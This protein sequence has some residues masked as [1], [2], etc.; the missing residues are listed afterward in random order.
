V[1]ASSS[2]Y[3][4]GSVLDAGATTPASDKRRASVASSKNGTST[5]ASSASRSVG[6]GA[7][8]LG[9]AASSSTIAR[10]ITCSTCESTRH[11]SG[12]ATSHGAAA[13]HVSI[14]SGASPRRRTCRA[15][16]VA[17]SGRV[18]SGTSRPEGSNV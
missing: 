12:I 7:I 18:K 5:H 10:V 16:R 6:E 11:V 13:D 8:P 17:R 4:R 9:S 14:P 1:R 2:R 3:Q 15:G